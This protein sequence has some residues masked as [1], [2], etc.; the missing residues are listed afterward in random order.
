MMIAYLSY[1]IVVENDNSWANIL[2]RRKNF[3]KKVYLA[4]FNNYK[5]I[6][7]GFSNLLI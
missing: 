7:R 6:Y 4:L 2:N 1:S 5:Y 3:L